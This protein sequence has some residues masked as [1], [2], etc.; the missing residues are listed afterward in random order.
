MVLARQSE[1]GKFFH[2][3][4]TQGIELRWITELKPTHALR[5]THRFASKWSRIGVT[6]AEWLRRRSDL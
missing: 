5:I 1:D 6:E 2:F 3:P 4:A